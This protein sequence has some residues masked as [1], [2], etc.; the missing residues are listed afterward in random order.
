[1]R[2][3]GRRRADIQSESFGPCSLIRLPAPHVN[4]P[5]FVSLFVSPFGTG[6]IYRITYCRRDDACKDEKSP[7]TV[8]R[9]TAAVFICTA[10][11]FRALSNEIAVLVSAGQM[12]ICIIDNAIGVIIN[13]FSNFFDWL[14]FRKP[15]MQELQVTPRSSGPDID[16]V[17]C[18]RFI[19]A[20]NR[21]SK[22]SAHPA[23]REPLSPA[24]SGGR[25]IHVPATLR[26]R[27]TS[28]HHNP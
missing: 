2:K 19:C 7:A 24:Q 4:R 21:D 28:A 18:L 8:C 23:P 12:P 14:L 3:G 25:S 17:D 15:N 9:Y 5:G 13:I 16:A 22:L 26:P 11:F 1:M 6:Y 20:P 10:A 27:A